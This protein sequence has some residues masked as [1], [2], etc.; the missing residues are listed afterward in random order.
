[1][2]TNERPG[3]EKKSGI[4]GQ[5]VFQPRSPQRTQKTAVQKPLCASRP[6]RG[7]RWLPYFWFK[8]AHDKEGGFWYGN[9][10]KQSPPVTSGGSYRWPRHPERLCADQ[11]TSLFIHP[12][13]GFISFLG[14][15][16]R[17]FR[18]QKSSQIHHRIKLDLLKTNRDGLLQ[19][20]PVVCDFY[21][22]IIP[23]IGP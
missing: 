21:A 16:L 8:K 6:S 13:K 5:T 19:K 23:P 17:A 11:R 9:H 10:C 4:S 7:L 12:F 14:N 15:V 22:M 18:R 3:R 2:G 1:M 20:L